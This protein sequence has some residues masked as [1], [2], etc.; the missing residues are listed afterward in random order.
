MVAIYN[1]SMVSTAAVGLGAASMWSAFAESQI[2]RNSSFYFIVAT[3]AVIGD[4]DIVDNR[5]ALSSLS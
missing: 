1:S 3:N 4:L 2:F 5:M